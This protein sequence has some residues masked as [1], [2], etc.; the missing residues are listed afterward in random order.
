MIDGRFGLNDVLITDARVLGLFEFPQSQLV[1]DFLDT[2][3][4]TYL[5]LT[6]LGPGV[7]TIPS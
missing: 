4:S 6:Y 1:H 2:Y 3:L 5:M 7:L